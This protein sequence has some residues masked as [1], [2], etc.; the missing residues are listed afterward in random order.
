MAS[1][2]GALLAGRDARGNGCTRMRTSSLRSKHTNHHEKRHQ[3]TNDA[4]PMLG[5]GIVLFGSGVN[6]EVSP[7]SGT[8]K[9]S[10]RDVPLTLQG[11]RRS[12]V[13]RSGLR[14]PE[15]SDD[16]MTGRRAFVAAAA[17]GGLFL[18]PGLAF[19]QAVVRRIGFLSAVSREVVVEAG[20]YRAFLQ[21]MAEL[22]YVEGKNLA[23]EARFAGAN[24]EALRKTASELVQLNVDVIFTSGT[25]AVRAARD[26]T[27]T[28]PIV[29]AT[30]EPVSTGLVSSLARP[31]G[32]I[33]GLTHVTHD[34]IGKR[35]ELLK[36]LVPSVVRAAAILNPQNPGEGMF[37][38]E[39]ESTARAL[40]LDLLI[41]RASDLDQI[42]RAISSAVE[43]RVQALM[44]LEDPLFTSNARK[45]A[46]L[47]TY[48]RLPA[49]YGTAAYTRSGGLMSYGANYVD[50]YRRAASYVDKILRG[51]KPGE[52]P[53][54]QPIKFELIVNLKAARALGIAVPQALQVR[55]D[56]LI[57]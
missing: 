39:M 57:Q 35:L 33:T 45:F 28:V 16:V 50:L 7:R 49:V 26:A 23:V 8:K 44:V 43:R 12:V 36:E 52:L 55:A 47:A 14:P 3:E 10:R 27:A 48:H 22:G 1:A 34:L 42:E 5:A 15:Q 13:G 31:G 18:L 11:E 51:A 30:G 54:E 32:N 4:V 29:M 41:L 37:A 9:R 40:H 38:G 53:I 56:E 21:G 20:N 17:A 46:D 25:T 24:P 19:A 6:P 2:L